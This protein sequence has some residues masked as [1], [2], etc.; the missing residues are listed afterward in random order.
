MFNPARLLFAFVVVSGVALAIVVSVLLFAEADHLDRE[1]H[2]QL[3]TRARA[4]LLTRLSIYDYGLSGARGVFAASQEVSRDEFRDYAA[5]L[6]PEFPGAIGIGFVRRVATGGLDR[7]VADR[8]LDDV[9]DFELQSFGEVDR[10]PFAYVIDFV[11]PLEPNR[12]VLGFDMAT[13]KDRREAA[14]LA[15]LTGQATLSA[16]VTLEQAPDEGPSFIYLRPVYRPKSRPTTTRERMDALLGWIYMPLVMRQVAD[17]ITKAVDLELDLEIYDGDAAT[18]HLIFAEHPVANRP[19]SPLTSSAQVTIGGRTWTLVVSNTDQFVK[20][21]RLAAWLVLLGGF[22]FL[23]VFSSFI[24]SLSASKRR[25][26]RLA[27]AMTLDLQEKSKA[28]E[29]LSLHDPLTGL[30]NRVLLIDRVGQAILRSQ[31]GDGTFALMFVDLDDFKRVND[32]LGHQGGDQV[33]KT[34]AKRLRGALRSCDTISHL[35]APNTV[36]RLGGDE[37]VVLLQSVGST[38]GVRL[39]ARRILERLS[40]P[41]PLGDRTFEVGASIGL[42]VSAPSHLEP[43]DLIREAD[44]AMYEAKARGK[45]SVVVY[46]EDIAPMTPVTPPTPQ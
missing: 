33:L 18:G 16:P 25:A 32:T 34:V 24:Y 20:A 43:D 31:R 19:E 13:H 39:V 5:T 11:E 8:R 6:D 40:A 26:E 14:D 46:S 9:P 29:R 17:G 21:S 28:L 27:A 3:A 42:V 44:M 35:G 15:A 30:P 38:E 36:A 37:F 2:E 41:I 45:G 7:W 12:G 23:T 22:A 4:L 10:G 1:R